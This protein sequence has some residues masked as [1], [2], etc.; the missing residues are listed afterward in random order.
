M[1]KHHLLTRAELDDYT[2][3]QLLLKLIRRYSRERN[4]APHEMRILDFG[5]GRG[6]SVIKLRLEG[7][8]AFGV[9]VDE[10]P[11]RNSESVLR[12]L[13]IPE[14]S[15]LQKISEDC[16]V[17]FPDGHFDVVFSQQ[18]VEHVKNIGSFF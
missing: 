7:F 3:N 1:S 14:G 12:S 9:D 16:K 5:C 8:D 6:R 17:P 10:E 18:V 13:G 15:Y 11:I 4:V 2:V